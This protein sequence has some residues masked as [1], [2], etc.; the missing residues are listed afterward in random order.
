MQILNTNECLRDCSEH[1]FVDTQQ[2]FVLK[3]GEVGLSLQK[4]SVYGKV[5]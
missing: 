4:P 5:I 3:V 2:T 1:T